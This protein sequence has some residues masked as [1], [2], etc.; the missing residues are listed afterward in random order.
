MILQVQ[1]HPR[2]L[3][4]HK[5]KERMGLPI[6]SHCVTLILGLLYDA[7]PHGPRVFRTKYRAVPFV[8]D[9]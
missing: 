7:I 2:S 5:S 3:I 9:S 6:G 1:G 8:V 4:L